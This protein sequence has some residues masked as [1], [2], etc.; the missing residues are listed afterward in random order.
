MSSDDAESTGQVN[1]KLPSS[2]ASNHRQIQS[3]ADVSN[4]RDD[5][6]EESDL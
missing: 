6:P 1:P 3:H 4:V 2:V 5:P